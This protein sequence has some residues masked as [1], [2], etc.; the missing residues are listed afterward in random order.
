MNASSKH[1]LYRLEEKMKLFSFLIKTLK[2]MFEIEMSLF[3]LLGKY[4]RNAIMPLSLFLCC[5]LYPKCMFVWPPPPWGC[6]PLYPAVAASWIYLSLPL[7]FRGGEEKKERARK[8]ISDRTDSLLFLL[9]KVDRWLWTHSA[10]RTVELTENKQS[11]IAKDAL[12]FP[13]PLCHMKWFIV[14][15]VIL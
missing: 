13:F 1:P 7:S 5:L 2:R 4:A 10:H 11:N 3:C 8:A 9:T 12:T 14:K 15:K 6:F